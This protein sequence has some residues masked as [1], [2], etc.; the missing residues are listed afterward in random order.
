MTLPSGPTSKAP[1]TT[2]IRS[3]TTTK[4][5][6]FGD[7]PIT[8]IASSITTMRPAD[9][10]VLESAELTG[11]DAFEEVANADDTSRLQD[12]LKERLLEIVR[13]QTPELV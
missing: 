12:S 6:Q 13:Q 9:D 1:L 11:M 2:T 5:A 8:R 7:L 4:L 3:I 10:V